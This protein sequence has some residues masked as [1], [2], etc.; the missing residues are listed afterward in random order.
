MLL[1]YIDEIGDF[2]PFVSPQH[3]KYRG[4]PAYG[5]GGFVIDESHARSIGRYFTTQKRRLFQ[6]ELEDAEHP[7]T[8]EM[9]GADV[10]RP[11]SPTRSPHQLRVFLNILEELQE[12][13]GK[14]FYYAEEKPL[15]T[16]RQVGWQESAWERRAMQETLNRLARHADWHSS[17]L[18]VIADSIDE[19]KRRERVHEMYG[20]IYGRS[21]SNPEMRRLL[22][23]PMHLDSALSSNIQLADWIAAWLRKLVD[24]QLLRESQYKWV[25]NARWQPPSQQLFTYESKLHFHQ[26]TL[27]DLNNS[28]LLRRN[29]PLFPVAHGQLL[30]ASIDPDAAR[31]MRGIAEAGQKRSQR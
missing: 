22:E 11:H 3:R 26:R 9:K 5:Y 7:S 27:Q 31:R 10:F 1:A 17:H 24:F 4:F 23:P 13:G 18:L 19:K 25:S 29:R 28:D 21:S 30:G 16:P 15:G 6:Q 14:L 8:W 12:R 2:G 20:H